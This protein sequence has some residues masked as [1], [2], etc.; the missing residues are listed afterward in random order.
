MIQIEGGKAALY[1]WDLNQRLILTSVGAITAGIEVHYSSIYD[2]E[3]CCLAALSYFEDGNIYADIPNKMLQQSGTISVYL[4][5]QEENKAW[6]EHRTEILVMPRKKPYNYVFG[7][8]QVLTVK[9]AV[10]N[11]LTK[12]KESGIFDGADGVD[13][14]DGYT[15]QKGVDYFDG[16]TG[17]SGATFTPTVSESGDLSWSNDKGLHNPPTVNI[18][19]AQGEQGETGE[20]GYTPQKNVDYFDGEDGVSIVSIEQTATSTE[21]N[22]ENVF[23]ITL[24][25]GQSESFSVRNGSKG[26]QGI[27]GIQGE[28]G[29][30]GEQGIQGIQGEKGDKGDTGS[31]GE[32]GDTGPQGEQGEAGVGIKS[33]VI[34]TMSTVDGGANVFS[35]HLTNGE[36]ESFVYTNGSKGSKGDTGPQGETGPQ[37]PKG[38]TGETGPQGPKGDTG[39]TGP[40]GPQGEAGALTYTASTTDITAGTT[41]LET[42]TFYFVYE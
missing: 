24:S 16:A 34:N 11:A 13:G 31:Q 18:K 12:A 42:G 39:D 21:D 37:G 15:P 10:E 30:Q 4:Y 32:Q 2:N 20:A 6:T 29:E 36:S 38:D 19:G 3:E 17:E 25:N 14:K 9:D 33:L 41:A 35:I 26:S 27:Q 28:K 40:Q 1:Q 5:V 23:K 7:E 8:T 22:G